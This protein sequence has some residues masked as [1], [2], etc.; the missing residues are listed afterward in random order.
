MF[1]AQNGR[2]SEFSYI[3]STER[4][5]VIEGAHRP[6]VTTSNANVVYLTILSSEGLHIEP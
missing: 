2:K 6:T 5:Y 1:N 3:K 4:T